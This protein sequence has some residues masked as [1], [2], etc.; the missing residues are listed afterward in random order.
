MY[1]SIESLVNDYG[2]MVSGIS[3]RMVQDPSLAEDASQ[4]VWLE[5]IKALPGFRGESKIST[6]IYTIT[7]RV[8]LDFAV[9]ERQYT[10]RF[11]RG[12]FHDGDLPVPGQASS[13]DMDKDL[14]VREMCDKCLTGMLHCLDNESR[15]IFIFKDIAG[16]SYE[17][18]AEIR[19]ENEQ[20]IRQTV[21]RTRRKLRNFLKDECAL[22]NPNGSCRCR[23]KKYVQEINLPQEYA[24][25]RS[26]TGSINVFR[27]SEKV[28]LRK[29]YALEHLA[30]PR[31]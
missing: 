12:Y 18:I 19:G 29:N 21:S 7:R 3:R 17:E 13:G 1:I 15:L 25:L 30:E 10:T 8:V 16:L 26:I 23:M 5:I 24:K 28:L 4:Q 14:W 27:D 9:N 11:L 2:K 22:V 31:H 6:W 20:A